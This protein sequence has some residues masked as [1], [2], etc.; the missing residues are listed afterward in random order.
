MKSKTIDRG[1]DLLEKNFRTS[2]PALLR[3]K[4]WE[5]IKK[6]LPKTFTDKMFEDIVDGFLKMEYPPKYA[7]F[8]TALKEKVGNGVTAEYNEIMC[9][10]CGRSFTPENEYQAE[11]EWCGA[12]IKWR[13]TPE[14]KEIMRR[15]VAELK[16]KLRESLKNFSMRRQGGAE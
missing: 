16:I 5:H 12:C 7:D 8:M 10:N 14:G 4:V 3:L 2:Y 13:E 6:S 15:R 9:S 11:I 1:F